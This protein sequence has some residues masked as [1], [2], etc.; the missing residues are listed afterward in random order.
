MVTL[1]PVPQKV[2]SWNLRCVEP[3]TLSRKAA[4][5]RSAMSICDSQTHA[6]GARLAA[7]SKNSAAQMSAKK[8]RQKTST[9][10]KLEALP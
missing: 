4:I 10:A 9:D 7:S 2:S 1:G 8:G 6:V 3:T 5:H